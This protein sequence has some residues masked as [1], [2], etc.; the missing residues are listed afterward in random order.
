[1]FFFFFEKKTALERELVLVLELELVHGV[2]TLKIKETY[3][4]HK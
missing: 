3:I 1:L 4:K 2:G